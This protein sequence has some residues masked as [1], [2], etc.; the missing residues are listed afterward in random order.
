MTTEE[1]LRQFTAMVGKLIVQANT[2][3]NT[4][5]TISEFGWAYRG[6]SSV[7]R[8]AHDYRGAEYRDLFDNLLHMESIQVDLQLFVAGERTRDSDIYH[9]LGT[10]WEDLGGRWEGRSDIANSQR[11]SLIYQGEK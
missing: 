5:C 7:G 2:H 9:Q 4:D 8:S 1:L 10:F 11:F 6:K 3:A